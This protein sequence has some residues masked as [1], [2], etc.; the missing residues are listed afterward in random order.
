MRV[1]GSSPL[2]NWVELVFRSKRL[3]IVSIVLA[4]IVTVAV[5]A[6]RAGNYTAAA[7]ILLS[8]NPATASPTVEDAN[9]R[10]SVK[11][12]LNVL[13][14]VL[15]DP[16]F[17]KEAFKAAGLDKGKNDEQFDKFCKEA[18]A[19]IKVAASENVM[20][21]SVRWPDDQADDIINAFFDA[22]ARNVLDQETVVSQTQSRVLSGMVEDYTNKVK[23]IEQKLIQARKKIVTDPTLSPEAASARY[24]DR[25]EQTRLL[26]NNLEIVRR[27]LARARALQA[28]TEQFIDA[29]VITRSQ[30]ES[31]LYQQLEIREADLNTK[32]SEA[33]LK[34]TDTHPNVK[35]L[36]GL[37]EQIK[38]QKAALTGAAAD[39]NKANQT[40]RKEP[41]PKWLEL[42]SQIFQ[43]NL[44]IENLE[45]Q[46]T[47]ARKAL[48]EAKTEA[49]A[50]PDKVNRL[51]WMTDKLALYE[52]IRNNLNARR[53]QALMD[54][55]KDRE[56]RLAEITM[57]VKPVAELEVVGSR[58]LVFYAAGPLLGLIIAFAFS[59]FSETLDHSLRTPV[60]VEKYLGKPVLAVLPR[61]E[62]PRG[63]ADRPR[64]SGGSDAATP[65]L[66]S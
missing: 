22:Y 36:E 53:E 8:G 19:A 2:Y 59:L 62:T 5:A 37:L 65:S 31:P 18:R 21:I 11:F 6:T 66:P 7:L 17:I 49:M 20:E 46:L 30:M 41:N 51:K 45:T 27:N 47:Y 63:G 28:N 39:K 16:N 32:L 54:E 3:F 34:Y 4:T 1:Y 55:K 42:D 56:M 23:D 57:M 25:Q 9:Q 48:M 61:M 52:S 50:S 24:R 12:K 13:N 60:E 29:S 10:G 33:K 38:Q 64:L 58:S 43:F 26:E 35:Q 14:I 40:V 44:Q 15:K